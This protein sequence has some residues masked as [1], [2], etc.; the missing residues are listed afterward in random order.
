MLI[1]NYSG[2]STKSADIIEVI[3]QTIYILETLGVPLRELS[4]RRLERMGMA[5]LAVANVKSAT[6]WPRVEGK[7]ALKSREIIVYI[8]QHFEEKISSGSYDDIRRRDLALPLAAGIIV[9]SA[10]GSEAARNDPTRAYKLA[11]EV[12]PIIQRF[13]APNWQNDVAQFLAGRATLAEQLKAHRTITR[14]SVNLPN[15]ATLTFSPGLHN[16]LQKAIIEEFLP[17]YGYGAEV[18]YVGD[19]ADKFLHLNR[20]KLENLHFFEIAHGQLPD[21]VAYSV[22]KNWLFLIEAVHTSGPISQLRRWQL[23][24]LTARCTAEIIYVT[25]FLD[26]ATFRR[27]AAEIAWETEVWI[28]D[29]P[30]HLIHFNGDK[31]LG[32]HQALV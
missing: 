19:A 2:N 10:A 24:Q 18:H 20:E 6:D 32:P 16:Q 12:V 17:R 5:F 7:T 1:R 27:F 22:Q 14:M 25:A 3:N 15:G 23:E 9:S 30:D 21:V 4:P 28:A 26:R 31:F 13:G 11:P 8:N 29:N